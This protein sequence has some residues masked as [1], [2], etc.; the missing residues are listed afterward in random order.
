MAK[1]KYSHCVS[2]NIEIKSDNEIPTGPEL[3]KAYQDRIKEIASLKGEE[4]ES[5][6]E[7]FES[8]EEE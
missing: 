5:C 3:L 6:F 2:L 4:L 7:V 8:D 1:K